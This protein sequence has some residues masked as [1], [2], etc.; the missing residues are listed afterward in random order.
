VFWINVPVGIVVL[1]LAPARLRESRDPAR[2]HSFDIAGALTITAALV[3]LVYAIAQVPTAG[4]ASGQ[5]VGLLTAAVGLAS[6]FILVEK[7][8]KV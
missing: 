4:W 5:S 7:R 2:A 6:L 3:L 1:V 8:S